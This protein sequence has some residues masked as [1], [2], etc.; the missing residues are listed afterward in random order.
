MESFLAIFGQLISFYYCSFDR[1]MIHGY[2]S[3]FHNPANLVYLFRDVLGYEEITKETLAIKTNI[4]QRWVEEFIFNNRIPCKWAEGERKDDYVKPWLGTMK[5]THK[6]GVYFVFKSMEYAPSFRALKPRYE[7][8]DPRYMIL[9]KS[10]CRFTH[11]YFYIRDEVLGPLVMKVGSYLPFTTTYYLNAHS[12][13][14][15]E[16]E[17]EHIGFQ[18]EDNA[19]LA[20]EN[21]EHLQEISER[22]SREVIKERLEY[23]TSL[24][25]PRFS[26]AEKRALSFKRFY[27][28][29]QVEYCVNFKFKRN[30]PIRNLFERSCELGLLTLTSDKIAYLFGQRLNKHIQGK[31]QT[32]LEKMSH[33]HHVFRAYFKHSFIK[34]YEKSSTFLRSEVVCNNPR[35]LKLKKSLD[36]LPAI[37]STLAEITRRFSEFQARIF[38]NH[39][40]CE[41]MAH[42]ARPVR[43]GL[44][45]IAGIHLNN[46]RLLRLMEAL[47]H[48]SHSIREWKSSDLYHYI[49]ENYDMDEQEYSVNQFRYD[50]RKLRAHGLL[51]RVGLSYRYR[52][53]EYGQ[54]VCIIFVLFHKK[55]YGPIANSLFYFNP[56]PHRGVTSKFE[57]AY[58]R[59]DKEIDKFIRLMAA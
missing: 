1:I 24:L 58:C 13:M 21:P 52:L 2:L 53:S 35:E 45:K 57:K 30:F 55:L 39:F 18:Q 4:Y 12:Y 38:N 59:I 5:R 15:R 10:R 16:L 23:W 46:K 8:D 6:W 7:T 33:G 9:K 27:S 31:L 20:A 22:F 19:F 54:K 42:L 25:A 28:I 50:L 34:Q 17:R 48:S 44:T 3:C 29:S 14:A 11:Y 37:Q 47:L 26:E 51:E 49:L 41:M 32:V 43:V 36:N 40:D 56:T